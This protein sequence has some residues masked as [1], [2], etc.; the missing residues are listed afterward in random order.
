MRGEPGGREAPDISALR[1]EA[2]LLCDA[3]GRVTWADDS[4]ARVLGIA[5]GDILTTH[6]VPGTEAKLA[7]LLD[8]ATR[9]PIKDYEIC[10]MVAGAPRTVLCSVF[11][12]PGQRL[13]LV[14]SLVPEQYSRMVSQVSQAV[15][16]LGEL[17]RQSDRQQRELQRR[18][19][20]LARLNVELDD[21][22]RGMAALHAEVQENADSL[23]R[24]SEVKSRVV[25]NVSHEFR[26]PLNSI[27]GLTNILLSR[28]DGELSPEQE[29]QI[30]F[31]RRS[32]ES[33]TELVN[34]LL[35]LS[36]IEA[37]KVA[38]RP[39]R[40]TV[41]SLFGALR[42]MLRPLVAPPSPEVTFET[43]DEEVALE[44]D[45]GKVSQIMRNLLSNAIKFA[46]EGD[47]RVQV[48]AEGDEV[49]FAVADSGIGIA[50]E[51]HE[52]VFEEFT[53]LDN[54]IQRRVKGTGLGLALSRRLAGI[55]GGTLVV[56]SS[57][58]GEGTTFELRIPRVHPEVTE[59]AA[60]E[61]RS[62]ALDPRRAPILVLEDDRQTLFL[63]E[64]YLRDAGFQIVPAR[65]IDDAREAMRRMRPAAIVLDVMLEGET[66]WA[67]LAELKASPDTRD[68]PALVVTITNREDRARAL[69]ADEFFV[70][71]LDQE[72]IARKLQQL[73]HRSG[74]IRTVL[75]VDDD[76]V[77]RYM[78]RRQLADS[79]YRIIEAADGIEGLRLAQLERPQVIF[80]DFVLPGTNAFDLLDDLKA[81][82]ATRNIPVI[83]HTSKSLADEEKSRLS[84]QAAAILPKQSLSREVAIARIRDALVAAGLRPEAQDREAS[85]AG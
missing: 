10:L 52:R 72:W 81:N 71:P 27:I 20:D 61:E 3:T 62:R 59:M 66:S 43:P 58:P 82:P 32:A 80:L 16:E 54:P 19:D 56:A 15:A 49:V 51:D 79:E 7:R 5:P 39:T 34:D 68:I 28:V 60:M 9:G 26:T 33:L 1:R 84:Q 78:L 17:Q 55:L 24:L 25:S 11:D 64:R 63:Y 50:P 12:Y 65:T 47:V 29:K 6:A 42:G 21:S 2:S 44:T 53:Q 57:A 48:R 40:F 41:A 73:A 76:E 4:A 46:P 75:V 23:R 35:D 77:A 85:R 14:G 22:A 8:E 69:G 83:I 37:G 30:T 31:I 45:E 18:H 36:S 74:P 70:K 38:F 67:F 13:L